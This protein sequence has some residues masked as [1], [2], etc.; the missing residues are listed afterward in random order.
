MRTPGQRAM[1]AT[2]TTLAILTALVGGV[3]VQVIA[4]QQIA[5]SNGEPSVMPWLI[6]TVLLWFVPFG[7]LRIV[8]GCS[9]PKRA[10]R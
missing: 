9:W 6:G 8:L 3:V 4:S 7:L 2:M 5:A 10:A 1:L